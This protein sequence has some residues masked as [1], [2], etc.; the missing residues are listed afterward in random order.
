MNAINLKS[1]I[2]P[3]IFYAKALAIIR[4]YKNANSHRVDSITAAANYLSC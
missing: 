3:A 1:E 4:Y 2:T